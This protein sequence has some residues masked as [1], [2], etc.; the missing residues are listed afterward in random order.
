MFYLSHRGEAILAQFRGTKATWERNIT[1][2]KVIKFSRLPGIYFFVLLKALLV[3][4]TCV[5]VQYP[6]G[7]KTP[8]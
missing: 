1:F 6:G 4:C 2:S 8:L 5:G 7:E 3:T